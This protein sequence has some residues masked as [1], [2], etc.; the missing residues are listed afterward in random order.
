M[1]YIFADSD[2][3]LAS[4][5][6]N[7]IEPMEGYTIVETDV[8]YD[9]NRI[10]LVNGSIEELPPPPEPMPYV[11][12]PIDGIP[13]PSKDVEI[14]NAIVGLSEELEKLKGANV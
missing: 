1:F 12:E 11:E 14:M 8:I 5:A 10:H 7:P 3:H 6:E 4:V 13:M 2:G 9:Y